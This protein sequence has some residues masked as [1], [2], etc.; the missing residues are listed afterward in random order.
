M[1]AHSVFLVKEEIT[2]PHEIVRGADTRPVVPVRH[3]RKVIGNLHIEPSRVTPAKWV[4]YFKGASGEE[5][6]A[7]LKLISA[8]ASGVLLAKGESRLFAVVFG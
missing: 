6:L 5:E 1:G 4:S 8:S 3:G 7:E 2:D